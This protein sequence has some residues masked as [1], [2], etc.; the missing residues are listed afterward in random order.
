MTGSSTFPRGTSALA[1]WG[2]MK[3]TEGRTAPFR[4]VRP[5]V[6]GRASTGPQGPRSLRAWTRP[7]NA[8]DD[9]LGAGLGLSA[10]SSK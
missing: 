7:W 10:V 4:A 3:E 9:F 1:G 8:A 5:S 6:F 2:E